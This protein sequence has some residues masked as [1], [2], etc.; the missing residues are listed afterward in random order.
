MAPIKVV[1]INFDHMHMGDLLRRAHENPEIEIVGIS[2]EQPKRMAD[3]ASKFG[4]PDE[5]IF[6]DYQQCL[7]STQ[8]DIAILCPSTATHG[9]WVERVAPYET[10]ILV[11]KPFAASLEEADRMIAA[12]AKTGKQMIINWPLAWYPPHVTSKRL[13]DEGVIGDV[14][15]VHYYDGNRGP[16]FH[17]ADKM[18]VDPEEARQHKNKSWWYKKALGGGSLIDYLGYGVTLGTWFHSGDKPIEIMTMVDE[19]VGLE[20]DEHSITLARYAKGLSKYETRWGTFTD[21]W[22]HQPQP[23]TG[24]VIVG[25]E[26]TISSYDYEQT[27]RVQTNAKPEGED[28]PVDVLQAPFQGPLQNLIH[29]IRTD[30]PV[31][32]PL[33]PEIGR[34]GQQIV[35]SAIL[36]AQEKRAVPLVDC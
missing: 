21:P 15:E 28:L 36:S 13:I 23:K 14:L 17:V 25:T 5:R 2:D 4:I 27:I 22:T 12:V 33:S 32:E 30:D 20:V 26:G 24:F 34:I 9:E 7:E 6:T 16:L 35:D 31:Y 11:E 1:G 3:A 18:P 10:H 8:P 19:P 29:S